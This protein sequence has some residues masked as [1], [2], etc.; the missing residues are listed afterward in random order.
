[1][2][3]ANLWGIDLGGTK[4]ECAVLDANL[5]PITRK[6]IATEAD[7]GYPHILTQI[8]KLVDQVADEVGERPSQIGFATPGTLE[9]ESQVMKN[10]NTVCMNGMPMKKDLEQILQL[11]VHLAND[12][13]CFALAEALM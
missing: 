2:S 9:P 3:T 4:V 13:N 6:R 5:Q 8:K 11:P 12:A 1:M 7:Q 10:C